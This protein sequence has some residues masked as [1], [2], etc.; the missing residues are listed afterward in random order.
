[1][2]AFMMNMETRTVRWYGQDLRLTPTEYAILGH[3]TANPG[4]VFRYAELYS[5]IKGEHLAPDEARAR[6]KSHITRLRQKI[7]QGG[8]YPQSVQ[9]VH[10]VGFKWVPPEAAAGT[11]ADDE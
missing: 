3:L 11:R 9:N 6:L 5:L 10:S 2:G 1:M 8:R 4:R 7:A